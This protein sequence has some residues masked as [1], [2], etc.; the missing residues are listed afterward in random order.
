MSVSVCVVSAYTFPMPILCIHVR[1]AKQADQI[2]VAKIERDG[3][4]ITLKDEKEQ[5]IGSFNEQTCR[6]GG[7]AKNLSA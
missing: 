6:V 4:V 3:K 5:V 2:R 7:F 1:G